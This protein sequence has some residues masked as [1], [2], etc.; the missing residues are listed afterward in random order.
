[1]EVALEIF[2]QVTP[3]SADFNQLTVLEVEALVLSNLHHPYLSI[4]IWEASKLVS[5]VTT[6]D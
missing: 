6:E 1:V 2:N 5:R 3:D 4:T